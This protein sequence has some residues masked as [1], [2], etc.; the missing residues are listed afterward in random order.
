V[1]PIRSLARPMLAATFVLD[2]VSG[3]REPGP[4]VDAVR[5]A[6]LTEPE[7]LV[8]ANA[9]TMLV[10]GLCLATGRLPRLSATALAAT[11]VPST[12]IRHAFWS[13]SDKQARQ[14]QQ[15]LF[16]KNLSMLGGLLIAASDTGGRESIP[17]RA[18]RL[19]NKASTK[20]SK[21][22][23]KIRKQAQEV[24]PD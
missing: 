17:H 10:S 9:G 16:F 19:S 20:A 6:G 18:G 4:R 2:G 14:S 3:L 11:I 23:S 13:E 12:F 22:A 24:L 5:A 7:K 21:Q 15:L 1:S 8:R